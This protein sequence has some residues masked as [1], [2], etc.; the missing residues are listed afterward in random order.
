MLSCVDHTTRTPMWLFRTAFVFL[1]SIFVR[2]HAKESMKDQKKPIHKVLLRK[3]LLFMLHGKKWGQRKL[4]LQTRRLILNATSSAWSLWRV[5]WDFIFSRVT[6]CVSE[7]R[8]FG[9][10]GGV[11]AGLQN[12]ALYWTRKR[13][14]WGGGKKTK[15]QQRTREREWTELNGEGKKSK[16][17]MTLQFGMSE[18]SSVVCK[19]E[20]RERRRRRKGLWKRG[21]QRG[22]IRTQSNEAERRIYNAIAINKK[23]LLCTLKKSSEFTV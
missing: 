12:G 21:R 1:P 5:F 2:F 14:N 3:S 13:R 19:K 4:F 7:H 20:R 23:P 16:L 8:H 15:Q 18:D 10:R 22:G 9:D 11:G 17:S 6:M